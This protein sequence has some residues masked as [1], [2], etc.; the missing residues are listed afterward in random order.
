MSKALDFQKAVH[1][2]CFGKVV[3]KSNC[4]RCSMCGECCSD[5]IPLTADEVLRL[6][7]F[8]RENQYV[9]NTKV[10]LGMSVLYDMTCPFLN[11]ENK[12]DVYD[13]R[14]DVCKLFRCWNNATESFEAFMKQPLEVRQGFLRWKDKNPEVVSLRRE[15][16]GEKVPF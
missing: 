14:P 11:S 16:F 9:A 7:R 15:I 12:C 3:D 2:E 1:G 6:R 4:G 8:V 10:K 5:I 13:I